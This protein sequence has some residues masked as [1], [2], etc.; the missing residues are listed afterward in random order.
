MCDVIAH[1]GPDDEGFYQD[2]RVSLGM[3]RLSIIDLA[4][5]HQPVTNE[6]GTVFI[7]FN[8]E[9]YNYKEL[10][11]LLLEKGHQLRTSSDTETIVHLYEEYGSACV[12]LLRGMFAFALWDTRSQTLL[13]ARDRLGVKPLY[14][15]EANGS[16][17][18][19]SEIKSL[20]EHPSVSRTVDRE[21]LDAYLTFQYVPG[22]RTLFAGIRKLP[23]GHILTAGPRG[24]SLERYWDL[25]FCEPISHGLADEEEAQA[26]LQRLLADAVRTELVAD[27]PLGA[28]LSGGIDSA[29]VVGL[30]SREATGPIRTFTVGFGE[31]PAYS[32]LEAARE[33]AHHFGAEFHSI[34]SPAAAVRLLPSLVWHMDEPVADPAALPTFLVCRY[35]RERVKVVLTGEGGDELFGGYPRYAWFAIAQRLQRSLPRWLSA[36]LSAPVARLVPGSNAG[37]LAELVLRSCPDEERHLA[38]ICNF[39]LQQKARLYAK[40]TNVYEARESSLQAVRERLKECEAPDPLHALMYLD[41]KSWLVDDILVKVD[42]M[43][44]AAS[45]EARVPLLDHRVVEFAGIL[46]VS[47]K[48]RGLQTK[49][50]LKRA[51]RDLLPASVL[52]RRKHAFQVPVN[53]WLRTQSDWAR[54]ILLSPAALGRG[55]FDKGYLRWMMDA[56]EGGRQRF[57]Q[58]IWNLVCLELWHQIFIDRSL[59]PPSLSELA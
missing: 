12:H 26:E 15:T 52:S 10:A 39:S 9:I 33:I 42:K 37:R 28:L 2:E 43:S 20:L 22:P 35:A 54:S 50:I 55:Y 31:H 53:E 8:G 34:G 48:V 45:L 6:D 47:Q 44:M 38:W 41:L 18:F 16:L 56:H 59:R 40:G 58:Q 3:R 49:R 14:Y 25:T 17:V 27:V 7:V 5:G 21:A 13:L 46:P 32:E 29:T 1:R 36:S 4:G 57:G 23:A 24:T 30:M 11:R 51:A 19:G